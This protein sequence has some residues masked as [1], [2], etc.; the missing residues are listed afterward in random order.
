M[1][2][3]AVF[4][5]T[6]VRNEKIYYGHQSI[7]QSDLDAA[8]SV[9]LSDY[10][11]C[12]PAVSQAEKDLEDYTGAK[13]ATL[14]SNGTA[15]LHLACIAA[16]IGPGDEVITTPLTFA[17]SANC[18]LYC[19][20][21]PVFADVNSDTYTIDPKDIEKKITDKTKAV[22]AVDFT[23]QTAQLDEIRDICNRHNLVFIEDAAHSIGTVYKDRKVGSIADMT[24]FSFH[25]VKN[26]TCGE[27]G[28]ILTNDA[29]Y[30]KVLKDAR[31][32][33]IV[34]DKEIFEYPDLNEGPWYY[35]QQ[36]LGY[37]YRLTDFQSAIL[38][39]Q[40]KKLDSFKKRRQEICSF[41]RSELDSIPGIILQKQLPESDSCN[42]LFVI[43]ID[44][45]VL[46]CSRTEFFN[47]MSKENVQCQ[48]HY[49]PVYWFPYYQR[50]GYEKGICPNAELI[51]CGMMSIP[52]YPALSDK[53]CQDVV[54]AIRKVA[55]YYSK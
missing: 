52:L 2:K 1:D 35:E 22:I 32:H 44:T 3:L 16:G 41:Y 27:G 10:I 13:Y 45:T 19:G 42:H 9:L 43:R 48:V 36:F 8:G 11:T 53:D 25:P 54:D 5:G 17:A 18:I 39:N 33:G 38:S 30:N 24:C 12:G 7:D 47:A 29:R 31:T 20:G 40:L 26:I 4:G 21:T 28:A 34:H 49:I 15:A 51:Y 50:L 14:V 46:N 55:L 23:G 37:N 6:P